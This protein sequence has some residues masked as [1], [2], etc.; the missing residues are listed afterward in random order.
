MEFVTRR[1][2]VVIKVWT[3]P[4][5][6]PVSTHLCNSEASPLWLARHARLARLAPIVSHLTLP[7]RTKRRC[8]AAP[9]VRCMFSSFGSVAPKSAQI[10]WL[11]IQAKTIDIAC[12]LSRASAM[13]SP[14]C[15]LSLRWFPCAGPATVAI[16]SKRCC[17]FKVCS[18][19]VEA[20]LI[21][22]C[23]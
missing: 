2:E 20:E 6:P 17:A 23:G 18:L 12:C 5:F 4:E 9:C 11:L 3:L 22:Q 21:H 8:Y 16:P 7:G 15:S 1:G 19:I 14:G 10:Q 13:R